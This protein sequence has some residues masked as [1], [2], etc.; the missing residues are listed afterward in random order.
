MSYHHGN[1]I[2]VSTQVGCRMGCRFCASTIMGLE[3]NLTASEI[4]SEVYEMERLTGETISN[5][6]LMGSGEPFD[7]YEEVVKFIR[8]ITSEKGRN[9]SVRNITLSTS[10]I[11]D[12]IREFAEEGLPVT[13]AL[14]LHASNDEKR[15]ELMP[16]AKKYDLK[17]VISACDYYFEKTGRRVSYEYAVVE[18][19][20]DQ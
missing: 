7:N 15:R 3:R 9:M 12:K 17:S 20:N 4:L 18:G 10:G 6:V 13:L 8:L 5:V 2:C 1:T 14:S 16:I 11:A 19:V